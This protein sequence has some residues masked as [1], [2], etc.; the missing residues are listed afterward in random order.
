MAT[1]VLY[2]SA[3]FDTLSDEPWAPARV[4]DAIAV[5][6]AGAEAAFDPRRLWPAHEWDEYRDGRLDRSASLGGGCARVGHG[7]A[8]SPGERRALAAGRRLPRPRHPARRRRQY[9][10]PAPARAGRG[11]RARDGCRPRPACGP[12]GRTRQL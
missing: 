7:P 11:A 3:Q 8:G 12:G 9:A 2:E 10:R 6:V 1:T 5:I 4:L